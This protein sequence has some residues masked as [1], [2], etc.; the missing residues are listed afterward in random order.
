MKAFLVLCL[1]LV[2][3]S[4]FATKKDNIQYC[5][6][7]KQNRVSTDLEKCVA[8]GKV[9]MVVGDYQDQAAWVYEGKLSS[10]SDAVY[11]CVGSMVSGYGPVF[12]S[13]QILK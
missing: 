13:C 6:L 9:G 1:A 7:I 5:N 10:R 8:T 12:G 2:S 4:A 11:R 3:T